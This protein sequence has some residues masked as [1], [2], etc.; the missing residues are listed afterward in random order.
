[1]KPTAR[2]RQLLAAPGV[3][4]APGAHDALTA[5]I[6]QAEGFDAVYLG[7]FAGS[8]SQLGIPDH[9]L[10]T[11]TELLEQARNVANVVDIPVIADIDDGGVSALSVRRTIRL[12]ERAGIAAVHLEDLI[13]G[14]HFVGHKDRLVSKAEA[15]DRIK[16]AVDARTD[17]DFVVIARSDAIAVTSIEDALDRACAYADAGAD[18][19]FLPRLRLKDT[20]KVV[21][22]V[23]RPLLNIVIDN[24]KAAL[25]EAGLKVGI[26]PVQSLLVSYSAVRSMMKELKGTG[27]IADLAK[28]VPSWEEFNDFIGSIEATRLAEKY[29]VI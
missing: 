9:S 18:L 2:L 11:M 21:K 7:G 14:K 5:R 4:L 22:A 13:P 28:R 16:A 1:M 10:V 15:V 23:P 29:R 12:A 19:L 6:V 26:Y 27:T 20:M 17:P 25:E 24:P 3:L 8:A